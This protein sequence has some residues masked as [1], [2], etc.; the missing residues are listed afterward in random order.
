MQA[1]ADKILSM[2]YDPARMREMG[3]KACAKVL[4][5]NTAEKAADGV[6]ACVKAVVGF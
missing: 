4:Q 3:K 6:V 5:E 1:L 2:A